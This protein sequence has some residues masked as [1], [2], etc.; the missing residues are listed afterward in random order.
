MHH[1][2]TTR[3][4]HGRGL[5]RND[6]ERLKAVL[7]LTARDVGGKARNA[8]ADSYENVVDTVKGTATDLQENV[9]DYVG[10]KP[11][12]AMAIASFLGLAFGLAMR[13][14]RHLRSRR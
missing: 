6:I 12:K 8:L 11:Y 4:K 7:A 9:A 14:K 1:K 10:S 3:T 5:I 13:R 2:H